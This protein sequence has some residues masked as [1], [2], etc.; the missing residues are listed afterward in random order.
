MGNDIDD[1]V[2]DEITFD[3]DDFDELLK[4]DVTLDDS[5]QVKEKIKFDKPFVFVKN[6][7]IFPEDKVSEFKKKIYAAT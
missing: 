7:F 2:L 3:D 1:D 6:I 4:D 5:K